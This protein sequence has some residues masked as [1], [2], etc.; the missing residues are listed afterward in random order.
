MEESDPPPTVPQSLT[1][2]E[3]ISSPWQRWPRCQNGHNE[4]KRERGRGK[5]GVKE[6]EEEEAGRKVVVVVGAVG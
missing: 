2:G 3:R 5:R 4:K 1:E 6:V